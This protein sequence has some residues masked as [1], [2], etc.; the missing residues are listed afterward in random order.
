MPSINSR[1]HFNHTTLPYLT[2]GSNELIL[3]NT[4][5]SVVARTARPLGARPL[6]RA[7]DDLT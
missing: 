6:G 7:A 4:E 5:F 2:D 1:Q 3:G